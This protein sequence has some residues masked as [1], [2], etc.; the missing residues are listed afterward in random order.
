VADTF[1]DVFV[2]C[3]DKAEAVILEGSSGDIQDRLPL[4]DTAETA[5][6]V[7]RPAFLSQ[8]RRELYVATDTEILRINT[9]SDTVSATF[10]V[11]DAASIGAVGYDNVEGELYVAR[12]RGFDQ[13]GTV[14]VRGRT[15]DVETTFQ[16][17]IAPT[18][19]DFRRVQR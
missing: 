7:G 10:D 3:S 13:Q 14:T 18:Y 5:F 16:A 19:I 6:G 1:S 17:G 12:E 11:D 2:F 9:V 4:P 15:G 8:S